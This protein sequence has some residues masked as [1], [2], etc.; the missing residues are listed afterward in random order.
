MNEKEFDVHYQ[1]ASIKNEILLLSHFRDNLF[2][3][4]KENLKFSS[5]RKADI[6]GIINSLANFTEKY[7]KCKTFGQL[8]S[9]R[10]QKYKL[11]RQNMLLCINKYHYSS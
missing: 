8:R 9:F 1:K 3:T 4:F 5:H 6:K 2:Y 7:P 11:I 10:P